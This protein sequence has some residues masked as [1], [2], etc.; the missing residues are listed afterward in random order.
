MTETTAA[1]TVDDYMECTCPSWNEPDDYD[2]PDDFYD[3][4]VASRCPCH[5]EG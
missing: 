1:R 4:C 5:E 3:A 2:G